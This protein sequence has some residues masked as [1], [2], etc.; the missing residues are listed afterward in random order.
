MEHLQIQLIALANV[1]NVKQQRANASRIQIRSPPGSSQI[2]QGHS[3]SCSSLSG[4]HSK[5]C[6]LPPFQVLR[7]VERPAGSKHMKLTQ[8]SQQRRR[9]HRKSLLRDL[10]DRTEL[11]GVDHGKGGGQGKRFASRNEAFECMLGPARCRGASNVS[12]QRQR[13]FA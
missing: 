9:C 5:G 13:T 11:K 4:H 6:Q 1:P 8:S 12:A 7:Q 2:V 3:R 10:R